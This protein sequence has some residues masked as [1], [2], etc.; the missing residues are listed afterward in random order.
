MGFV[1]ARRVTPTIIF[2]DGMWLRPKDAAIVEELKNDECMAK[3]MLV[4]KYS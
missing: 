4:V 2:I 1:T 3:P